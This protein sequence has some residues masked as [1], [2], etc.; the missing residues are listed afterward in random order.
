MAYIHKVL[1]AL[2]QAA[3]AILGGHD[4]ETISA[5]LGRAAQR[6][7]WWGKAGSWV[8]NAVSPGHTETA[9]AN[10]LRRAEIVEQVEEKAE[11]EG[12]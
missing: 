8:L 7:K 12:A 6:G 4:D 5:R 10:D 3:N 11:H 1:V 9:I 2:D